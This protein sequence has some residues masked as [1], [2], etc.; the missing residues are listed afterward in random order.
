METIKNIVT[1]LG[2]TG[3]LFLIGFILI[4]YIAIGFLYF[5][6]SGKQKELD[7]QITKLSAVVSRPLLG[8]EELNAKYGEANSALAPMTDSTAIALLVSIAEQSG[9][10]IDEDNAKFR[11]PSAAYSQA[12]VGGGTYYLI[13]FYKIHL[14][15][16]PD[17]VMT[18]I[19]D[20]DSGTTLPTMVLKKAVINEKIV[21]I[22]GEEQVRRNEFRNVQSAVEVMMMENNL[23][24]IPNPMSASMGMATNLMGDDP[25]VEIATQGF[26][27][28]TTTAAEKGYTGEGTPRNGYVLYRHD[29]IL[30]EN[31]VEYDT[32]NYYPSLTTEYFYTCE[33]DG[34]VRQ[35][36]G[37]NVAIA[38]EYVGS[39]A[40]MIELTAI[41][42]VDIYTKP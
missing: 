10:D 5:Q 36:N 34:T 21:Q 41:V 28:I 13:S 3:G 11:V 12:R 15:G 2:P 40:S 24:T 4:V 42:D 33:A 31:T 16:D 18:F 17:S 6:Q 7:D 9:I 26:P 39:E 38:A 20:L 30:E 19:A 23:L 29:I 22:G 1:R 37:P 14:E 27:D 8:T 35:W 32:V 25:E